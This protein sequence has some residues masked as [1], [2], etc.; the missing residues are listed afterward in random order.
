V[1]ST[2]YKMDTDGPSDKNANV[3]SGDFTFVILKF[4]NNVLLD[5]LLTTL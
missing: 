4:G 5:F 3:F 1:D 2:T